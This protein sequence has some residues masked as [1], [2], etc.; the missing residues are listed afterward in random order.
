MRVRLALQPVSMY[1]NLQEC[2]FTAGAAARLCGAGGGDV[3]RAELAGHGSPS[4]PRHAQ[5]EG[6]GQTGCHI[7]YKSRTITAYCDISHCGALMLTS[8]LPSL[9][10]QSSSPPRCPTCAPWG[11]WTRSFFKRW[12]LY[13]TLMS[14]PASSPTFPRSMNSTVSVCVCELLF[15]CV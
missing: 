15:V 9:L 2:R 8:L 12:G 14:W 3:R 4:A 5:S 11:S 1:A 6:G 13:W 7:R 10:H